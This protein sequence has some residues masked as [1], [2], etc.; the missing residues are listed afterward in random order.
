MNKLSDHWFHWISVF[1]EKR[2][3]KKELRKERIEE[4]LTKELRKQLMM[5]KYG[6]QKIDIFF[7]LHKCPI[8][9]LPIIIVLLQAFIFMLVF[10]KLNIRLLMFYYN[11]NTR[12]N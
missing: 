12:K 7:H 11:E 2:V 9:L 5:I 10:M 6:P 8:F 1:V 3:I 4:E